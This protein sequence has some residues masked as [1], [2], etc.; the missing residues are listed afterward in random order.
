MS[1]RGPDPG[2]LGAEGRP[3]VS[4]GACVGCRK[5]DTGAIIDHWVRCDE[6]GCADGGSWYHDTCAGVDAADYQGSV[7]WIC[8]ACTRLPQGDRSNEETLELGVNGVEQ[9]IQGEQ[10]EVVQRV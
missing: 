10:S 7:K 4:A 8:P 1:K 3:R 9:R 6:E 5:R 2:P